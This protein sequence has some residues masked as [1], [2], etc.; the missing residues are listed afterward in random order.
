MEPVKRYHVWFSN[1]HRK[2]ALQ[3][4]IGDFVTATLREI[5]L[6]SQIEI[7]EN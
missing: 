4:E 6:R 2:E 3:D 7:V 1:R 5:A